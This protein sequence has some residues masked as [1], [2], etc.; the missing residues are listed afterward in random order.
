MVMTSVA[1]RPSR[2]VPAAE[3]VAANRIVI[4]IFDEV[5]AAEPVW[6]RL[7]AAAVTTPYQ[8]YDWLGP[9]QR[10]VGARAGVRP[11]I[12]VGSDEG[13]APVFLL[14][15]GVTRR[16]PLTTAR[17]LGG[18][19]A[20][21]NLGLWRRDV[22]AT[23]DADGIRSILDLLA[24]RSRGVDLLAL[25]NQPESWDGVANPLALLPR[26]PSPSQGYRGRLAPDFEPYL[27]TRTNS[28]A[29]KKFRRKER[30]LAELGDIRFWRVSAAG[31]AHRVL[32][33]FFE[34]KAARMRE[35]GV[36]NV[37]SVPGARAFITEAATAGLDSGRPVVELY[38]FTVGDMTVATF[39]GTVAGGRF[40][41]MFNSMSRGDLA[42]HS[43]GELLLVNLVRM[44][45]ERGLT[46]FD[47]GVG[48]APYKRLFCDE[49]EPLFD[50]F[51]PLTPLGRMAAATARSAYNIKGQIK[52]TPAVWN[53]LQ[54]L[55]RRFGGANAA[56]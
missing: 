31:D 36:K 23:M 5:T 54:T 34:Q 46:T 42:Q 51:L 49:T 27:R 17:F 44:C 2:P 40:C 14:P 33:T 25:F 41:G 1:V 11:F 8:R 18:K 3:P 47:L 28:A 39:A 9:W 6:R 30:D 32:D 19:H 20:N 22:A 13:G 48:E 43:P 24:S 16:G 50:S 52:R 53:A 29:R 35:L 55:R 10:H 37:F 15:L 38:A 26:Q 21:F 56:E 12:V 7:E 4:S 45:C